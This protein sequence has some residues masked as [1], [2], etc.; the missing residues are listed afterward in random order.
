[1][2]EKISLEIKNGEV[3]EIKLKEEGKVKILELPVKVEVKEGS[4]LHIGATPSPLTEK[5]G[6][7]FKVDR[8]PVIPATSFKGAL[9]HQLELLFI[10]KR[11]EFSKIFNIN[12]DDKK[13]LKPCIP[14]P[15]RT[16]AEEELINSGNYRNTHCEIKINEK[17]SVGGNGICPVCYFMG[18]T[19][20]MGFLRFNNLY[21]KNEGNVI[22]QTNIRID[23]KTGTAAH[24][25]KVDGEQ[26]K[27]GTVFRGAI[28][29]VVSEPILEMQKIQFGDARKIENVIIDKWLEY[30]G[31]E[32]KTKRAKILIEKVIIPAINNIKLL[33][34]QKS[35][36][37]GKVNTKV[38]L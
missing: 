35:R 21:P 8:T 13:L 30:W 28:D 15:R 4:F 18:A 26:V 14:S 5:K 22:D 1:M 9:R 17:I 36:G 19:G 27:P 16:K 38:E 6:A 32:D 12:E 20:L 34:G 2:Y 3:R 23:R 24:G 25:A 31:E 11:E 7:I 37:G 10:E 33:G 29:I